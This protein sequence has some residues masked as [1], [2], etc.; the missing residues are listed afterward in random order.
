MKKIC[1]DLGECNGL[2][3]LLCS[4][5]TIKKLSE[6]YES[7]IVVL[8]KMPELFK[9]NPYVINSYKKS[10]IDY[11]Y[12]INNGYIIHNSFYNVG[13]RN[14]KGIE[15]K[16]NIIDIRQF[17]AI[18]LGFT[19]L[20]DEKQCFY[21][22]TFPSS[23]SI[24]EKEY[25]VIHPVQSWGSRTWSEESWLKLSSEI[26]NLG[27]NVIAIGKESSETGF[28]NV[29]KPTYKLDQSS[30]INYLNK[31]NIS[32]AWYVIQN[33]LGIITMDSGLLHLA[34]TTES[35]IYHLGSSINPEY[36]KPYRKDN[37][38]YAYIHGKCKKFCASDMKYGVKEWG[39]I[40]GVPPLIGCLENYQSFDCHPTY[41]DVIET[42]KRINNV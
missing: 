3:D 37:N 34:G 8:S 20:E 18:N 2:G 29:Q 32:D 11:D 31:T 36:R 21:K 38:K 41:E 16:H 23:L 14:E 6:A 17:H 26:I 39:T 25:F 1:L 30:I 19:L 35:F 40:Q 5:P 28:F 9:N 24:S 22:P 12:F 4:T 42:I 27:Y 15:F 33:S 7:Q 13:K 10:S